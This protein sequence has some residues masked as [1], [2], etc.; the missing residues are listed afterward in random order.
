MNKPIYLSTEDYPR[1]RALVSLGRG[2]TFVKLRQELER[3]VVLDALVLPSG[4]VR[5]G[6]EVCIRDLDSGE[7]EAYTLCMP[8]RADAERGRLSVL[9]PVGMALI[10]Y[11]EGDVIEWQT[12]GGIRRLEIQ[13]VGVPAAVAGPA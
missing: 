2:E 10:G 3:A 7:A 1:I 11:A 4:V 5:I 9:A 12:P 13:R 8:D 6:S